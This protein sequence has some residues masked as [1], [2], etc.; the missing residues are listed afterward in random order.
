MSYE[1]VTI[2]WSTLEGKTQIGILD[3]TAQTISQYRQHKSI[4]TRLEPNTDYNYDVLNDG[5]ENGKGKFTTF[6]EYI[7]PF[8]FAVLGDTRTR[9]DVHQK[10]VNRI[11]GENPISVL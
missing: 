4:I 2:C 7:E 1:E 9:H 6:P 3:S 8:H 11:I 5:T 10:I